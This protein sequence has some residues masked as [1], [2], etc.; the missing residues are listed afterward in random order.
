MGTQAGDQGDRPAPNTRSPRA[1]AELELFTP[2]WHARS[3]CLFVVARRQALPVGS[4]CFMTVRAATS[5]AR[6]P[7]RP[8]FAALSWMCSY[9]RC[10]FSPT[11]RRCCFLGIR[12]TFRISPGPFHLRRA[13]C[14][15]S[16]T[17]LATGRMW[18]RE[19][20]HYRRQFGACFNRPLLTS[21]ISLGSA[22]PARS[23]YLSGKG[24]KP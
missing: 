8:D 5:F 23:V 6:E 17:C 4:C 16:R 11:P 10:S 2:I 22:V 20:S 1:I 18:W 3:A 7:Y 9:C 12:T 19:E 24:G 14:L 13:P 15:S 21:Y